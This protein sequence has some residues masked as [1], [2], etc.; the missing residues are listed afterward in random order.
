VEPIRE[1]LAVEVPVGIVREV[2]AVTIPQQSCGLWS[3][4]FAAWRGSPMRRPTPSTDSA[5]WR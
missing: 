5:R 3:D 2:L 4:D 1:D